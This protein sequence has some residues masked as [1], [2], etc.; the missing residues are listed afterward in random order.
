MS[1]QGAYHNSIDP[2]GRASIPARFR[3]VLTSAFG[4]EKLMVTQSKGGLVAY[5]W[6][7]WQII[8]AKVE[9]L[10]P[11][12]QKDDIYL[13]LISPA[14]EGVFDRQGRI[15]LTQAHR[16]YAGLN[17]EI[18]EVVVVGVARKIMLW[19]K[20]K[21]AEIRALAERRLETEPQTLHDLGF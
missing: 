19:S 17:G 3:D 18:R 13:T 21:H 5:P 16:D 20:A 11:G 9:S 1:F 4:D 7:E 15:Q 8:E 2:K 14:A 6:S 10:P 12:Q